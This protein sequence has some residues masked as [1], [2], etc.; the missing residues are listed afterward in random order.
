MRSDFICRDD[1]KLRTKKDKYC[2]VVGD[3]LVSFNDSESVSI[4]ANII[5]IE[6]AKYSINEV[7][8]ELKNNLPITCEIDVCC[9]IAEGENHISVELVEIDRGE[10]EFYQWVVS[11]LYRLSQ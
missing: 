2:Q 3:Y 9:Q 4:C 6:G 5:L 7:A 10:G 11:V 1:A 8:D